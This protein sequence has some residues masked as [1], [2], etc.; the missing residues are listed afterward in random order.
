[1]LRMHEESLR[2]IYSI[3]SEGDGRCAEK[4]T[5]R[6]VLASLVQGLVQGLSSL[7]DFRPCWCSAMSNAPSRGSVQDRQ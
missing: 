3:Y 6:G 1:M 4:L 7:D 2:A 5:V